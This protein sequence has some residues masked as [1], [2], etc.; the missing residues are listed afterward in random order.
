M[1]AQYNPSAAPELAVIKQEVE[2]FL[3]I[4]DIA[5]PS[6]THEY[7]MSR[8]L[9]MK[10]AKD[11]T[12][13]ST[14]IIGSAINRDHSTVVHALDALNFEL[15]YNKDLQTKY[16]DLLIIMADTLH[17]NTLAIIDTKI[18]KLKTR[19]ASL[20]AI[21]TKLNYNELT[22]AEFKNQGHGQVFWS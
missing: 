18:N 12:N 11:F 22:Y 19:L 2:K 14:M 6:R 8:W 20:R 15:S 13:Y 16:D 7:A 21:K 10:L 5:A 1:K 4:E 9:Y 3:N 17:N